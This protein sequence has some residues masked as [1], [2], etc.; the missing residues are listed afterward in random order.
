MDADRQRGA[1]QIKTINNWREN[2]CAIST[3]YWNS[4]FFPNGDK[5]LIYVKI[6]IYQEKKGLILK[7]HVF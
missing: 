3:V 1:Q 2:I 7:E 5:P 6:T 4:V